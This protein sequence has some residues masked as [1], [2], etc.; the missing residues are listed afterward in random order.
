MKA[1]K[2]KNFIGILNLELIGSF[3]MRNNVNSI[4][5]IMLEGL[6]KDGCGIG[7]TEVGK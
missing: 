2:Y 7:E 6:P 1:E 3:P 5:I 4:N